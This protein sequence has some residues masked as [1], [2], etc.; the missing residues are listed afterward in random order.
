MDLRLRPLRLEDE[1]AYRAAQDE[2]LADGFT[3]GFIEA[4]ESFADHVQRL[5]RQRRGVD[6]GDLVEATFLVAEVAGQIVGRTSIRHELNDYLA[7]HGGH[8]GY[9]VRPAFRRHGY[10]TEIL[11]QSLIIAR[12]YGNDRVLV[13]CDDANVASALVIEAC[14]GHLERVVAGDESD[15]GIPFRRHWIG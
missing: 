3:F 14:G 4:G 7:F 13:T 12:S 2:L 11:R 8:V 9:G 6:L 5:Q 15:D 1:D 10:A